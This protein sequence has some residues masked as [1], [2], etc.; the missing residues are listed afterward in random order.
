MSR[1]HKRKI[2]A[3]FMRSFSSAWYWVCDKSF[4]YW[5]VAS[6]QK[7][8][9]AN[10]FEAILTMFWAI[11]AMFWDRQLAISL[12]LLEFKRHKKTKCCQAASGTP[13]S[14]DEFTPFIWKK[15][16]QIR[17]SKSSCSMSSYVIHWRHS[18]TLS[19]WSNSDTVIFYA[20]LLPSVSYKPRG[21]LAMTIREIS[22]CQTSAMLSVPCRLASPSC[23]VV[24]LHI[25]SQPADHGKK[26]RLCSW[27]AAT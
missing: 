1:L 3:N 23:Q 13:L 27:L 10:M 16:R 11:W 19:S 20:F 22:G 12:G 26:K 17:T 6:W 14:D 4:E 18:T 25:S 2:C 8:F 15:L 7:V 24:R 21:A 5:K 9:D